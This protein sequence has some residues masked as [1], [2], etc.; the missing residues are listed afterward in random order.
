MMFGSI[1]FEMLARVFHVLFDGSHQSG[2]YISTST[3]SCTSKMYVGWCRTRGIEYR[4]YANVKKQYIHV[5]YTYAL[6]WHTGIPLRIDLE[7]MY[8]FVFFL[9]FY[10]SLICFP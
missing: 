1:F 2:R 6:N 3:A 10:D 9:Q 5:K 7:N 4:Q 8:F